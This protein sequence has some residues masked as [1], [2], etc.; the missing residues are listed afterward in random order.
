VL[1]KELYDFR[2][3]LLQRGIMFAYSGYITEP[4]LSGVGEALL[5]VIPMDLDRRLRALDVIGA[6]A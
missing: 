4:V 5:V 6:K 1:A 2:A 3:V